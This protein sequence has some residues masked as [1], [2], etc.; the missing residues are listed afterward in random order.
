[1][2]PQALT[3]VQLTFGKGLDQ[4]Y[5]PARGLRLILALAVGRA[6]GKTEPAFDAAIG[7]DGEWAVGH[8]RFGGRTGESRAGVFGLLYNGNLAC[9]LRAG[10]D[11]RGSGAHVIL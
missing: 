10:G 4:G 2:P 11:T 8:E 7:F 1:M 6:S 3:V 9:Q 5:P